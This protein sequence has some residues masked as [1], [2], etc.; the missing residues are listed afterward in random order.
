MSALPPVGYLRAANRFGRVVFDAGEHF[1]K[2]S[3]RNRY[4][5]LTANGVH[6]LTI[7]LKHSGRLKTPTGEMRIDHEKPWVKNHL[8]TIAA[9]Y[10]SAPFYHHYIPVFEALIGKPHENLARFFEAS[11]GFWGSVLKTDFTPEISETYIEDFSGI[12]GRLRIKSPADVPEEWTSRSYPQVFE[13]RY[14]FVPNLCMLDLLFN[15]GPASGH[16]L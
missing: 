6:T 4:H 5:I 8:R 2:Q 13:D 11:M 14:G 1:V 16:W 9:A 12:D 10:G 15:E 3:I 7:P